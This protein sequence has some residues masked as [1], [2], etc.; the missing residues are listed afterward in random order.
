VL[1]AVTFY[2]TE[3]N[4]YNAACILYGS[5]V[6]LLLLLMLL[7]ALELCF[8]SVVLL[9]TGTH[10]GILLHGRIW[11]SDILQGYA[12]ILKGKTKI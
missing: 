5:G 1:A 10:I 9:E 4:K 2:C 8:V 3:P 12:I 11:V 7:R 6:V